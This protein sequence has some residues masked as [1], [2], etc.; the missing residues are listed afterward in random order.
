[1]T[2]EKMPLKG[3]KV[4]GMYPVYAEGIYEGHEPFKIVG[5]RENEI[6]IEGDFSGGTHRVSQKDWVK[7]DDVFIVR[8][9]CEEETKE[10]GCQI[11]NVNCCGGG[12]VIRNHTKYWER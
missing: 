6:E 9:L 1:M 8:T 10:K 5:I 11:H 4:L 3:H 7:E 12:R 2:Y